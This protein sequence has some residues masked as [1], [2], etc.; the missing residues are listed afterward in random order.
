MDTKGFWNNSKCLKSLFQIYL[1]TCYES[2]TNMSI[3]LSPVR[4]ILTSKDGP[5]AKELKVK[6]VISR[7][8]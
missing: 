1:N 4:Q 5:S 8:H 3:S 7:E 2:P 6:S